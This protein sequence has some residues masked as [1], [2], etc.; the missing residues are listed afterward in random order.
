MFKRAL[1][2][3]QNISMAS[4]FMADASLGS[5]QISQGH[6][7]SGC[8]VQ[9]CWF[10]DWNKG[11][12]TSASRLAILPFKGEKLFSESLNPHLVE[13]TGKRKVLPSHKKDV[14]PKKPHLFVHQGPI[15][16]T[17]PSEI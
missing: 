5:V 2:S 14:P 16:K 4:A 7:W 8:D 13:D 12:P 11:D 10:R 1:N 3:H 6:G 9:K 17:D 15:F